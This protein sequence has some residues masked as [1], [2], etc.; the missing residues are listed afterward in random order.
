MGCPFRILGA[1]VPSLFSAWPRCQQALT[2]ALDGIRTVLDRT[3]GSL[4][5]EGVLPDDSGFQRQLPIT[6]G[7]GF[8]RRLERLVDRECRSHVRQLKE[9]GAVAR[10]THHAR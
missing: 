9:R 7:R 10:R 5:W 8:S 6:F 4:A 1:G 3:F 2:T